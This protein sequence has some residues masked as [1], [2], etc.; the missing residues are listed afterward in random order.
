VSLYELLQ[1]PAAERIHIV[2]G[3]LSRRMVEGCEK[4]RSRLAMLKVLLETIALQSP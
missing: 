4:E 3:D 1:T 2:E